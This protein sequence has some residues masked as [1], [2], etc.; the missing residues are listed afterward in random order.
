MLSAKSK[1]EAR[2]LWNCLL[3][4]IKFES[5]SGVAA[6]FFSHHCWFKP[7]ADFACS[8][9]LFCQLL[10]FWHFAISLKAQLYSPVNLL[11]GWVFEVRNTKGSIFHQIRG[12]NF[13][14]PSL[15]LLK[16][17]HFVRFRN[18]IEKLEERRRMTTFIIALLY[19]KKN[20]YDTVES[21]TLKM[22]Q[23]IA[24]CYS[25]VGP[26]WKKTHT[27]KKKNFIGSQA[28]KFYQVQTILE[29]C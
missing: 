13:V 9:L 20:M 23:N 17:S 11:N 26:I 27:K 5:Y 16:R 2:L 3:E 22:D 19:A 8:L 25:R 18:K 7:T 4:T 29:F 14:G 12:K 1:S 24:Y 15:H 28:K 6:A 10:R 21:S